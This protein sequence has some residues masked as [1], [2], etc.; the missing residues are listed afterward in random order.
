MTSPKA[1][2]V[3]GAPLAGRANIEVP[4]GKDEEG[5]GIMEE[6]KYT[7]CRVC[8]PACGLKVTLRDGRIEEVS[9]DQE[10]PLSR[11]FIC[12]RG[13][14]TLDIHHSPDRVDYPLK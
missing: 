11:G 10:H 4:S 7:Y 2:S 1:G 6:I 8:E 5:G 13:K 14:A 9:G 3:S 12:A